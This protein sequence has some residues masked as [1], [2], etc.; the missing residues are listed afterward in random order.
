MQQ[1]K[2]LFHFILFLCFFFFFSCKK[3]S[4]SSDCLL[5]KV[6]NATSQQDFFYD[7]KDRIERV[8]YSFIIDGSPVLSSYTTWN[9]Y[10]DSNRIRTYTFYNENGK[11]ESLQRFYY[12]RD[13]LLSRMETYT[14]SFLS[15]GEFVLIEFITFESDKNSTC[16]NSSE[17]IFNIDAITQEEELIKYIT[18]DYLDETC[19]HLKKIY[20]REGSLTHTQE[21]IFDGQK[22]PQVEPFKT[23]NTVLH[24]L[25]SHI[26]RNELNGTLISES[27]STYEYNEE[28]Y[29]VK[30]IRS[31]DIGIQTIFDYEYSCD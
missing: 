7:D 25:I 3:K 21:L 16:K 19:S 13:N 6:K 30:R 9:Y 11:K 5:L 27:T 24:N 31:R 8:E 15:A 10:D 17:S 18:Y 20:D 14:E 4:N 26:Y 29:P 22:S 28:G 1:I 12:D 2:I 23:S